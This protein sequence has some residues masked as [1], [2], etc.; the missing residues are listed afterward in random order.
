[1]ILPHDPN[2]LRVQAD[3]LRQSNHITLP[4]YVSP[5]PPMP[6]PDP[7]FIKQMAH[8]IAMLL[9]NEAAREA[10]PTVDQLKS[11]IRGVIRELQDEG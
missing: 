8:G 1:M 5:P 6:M 3:L 7:H 11:F 2:A 9:E 10:G 4:A